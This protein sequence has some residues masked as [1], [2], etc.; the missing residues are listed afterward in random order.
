[1]PARLSG[2]A[3]ET[4]NPVRPRAACGAVRATWQSPRAARTA[5][6]K[7][8]QRSGRREF[9]RGS[10][11]AGRRAAGRA[12]AAAS[13]P[14]VRAAARTRRRSAAA[15]RARRAR[16]RCARWTPGARRR[17]R[18]GRRASAQRPASSIPNFAVRRRR[19]APDASG[20][21]SPRAP[22]SARNP[23]KLS[24]VTRPSVTS[25][26]SAS[27]TCVRSRPVPSASSSKNEA[28]CTRM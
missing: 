12:T 24:D 28:P 15:A 2:S 11:A 1:M 6:R 9:R 25:S 20:L 8:R 16:S 26:P 13:P 3:P 10:R 23:P 19:C 27:S 7:S 14:R 4:R 18:R 21:R 22:A 17:S 5:R